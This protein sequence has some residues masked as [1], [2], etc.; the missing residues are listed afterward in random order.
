MI[1][2][3]FKGGERASSRSK[4]ED[5]EKGYRVLQTDQQMTGGQTERGSKNAKLHHK[6]Q[7]QDCRFFQKCQRNFVKPSAA[8]L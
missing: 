8:I 2:R 3:Y 4:G 6:N 5:N 7:I 1:K